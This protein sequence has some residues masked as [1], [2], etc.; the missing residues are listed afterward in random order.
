MSAPVQKPSLQ[1]RQ[2]ELAAATGRTF[3]P[4]PNARNAMKEDNARKA[5][6]E[7][8]ACKAMKNGAAALLVH[9]AFASGEFKRR[10]AA[11]L[12]RACALPAAAGPVRVEI[13]RSALRRLADADALAAGAGG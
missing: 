5:I 6:K 7:D 12:G 10:L 4:R 3:Y 1:R 9:P 8:N 13:A 11:E 2:M